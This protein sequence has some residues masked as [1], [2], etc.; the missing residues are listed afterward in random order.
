MTIK[1]DGIVIKIDSE[2]ELN[3]LGEVLKS[4]ELSRKYSAEMRKNKGIFKLKNLKVKFNKLVVSPFV[5]ST[6]FTTYE[7]YVS[8]LQR[9][10]FHSQIKN[11]ALG[12]QHFRFS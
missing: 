7:E 6:D 12:Q 5:R 2:K 4:I 8:A 1:Y 11:E 10:K 3:K 9:A